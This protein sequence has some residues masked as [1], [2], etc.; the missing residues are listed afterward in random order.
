[1]KMSPRLFSKDVVFGDG[2]RSFKGNSR[3]SRMRWISENVQKP[4]VIIE[5]LQMLGQETARVDWRLTGQVAAGNIDIFVQSTIEMNVLTGR[6][7]SHKDS[8]DTG[9]MA[10][11][12]SLLVAASRAAWAARQAVM[13]A[14][15]KLS[16]A[17]DTLTSTLESSMDD[18]SGVYR[19]PTD[20][21]KFFQQ[22][23][24]QENQ[25]DMINFAMIAIAIW[26][27][28]KGFSTVIQ[29]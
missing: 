5:R 18:D 13:D 8:W 21:T 7:L 4:K 12:V 25:N 23:Q 14:Q 6:I 2:V 20:P 17:A 11:P 26:A 19:D 9:G 28:Y 10:P 1:M 24:K 29:L 3:Y 22:S 27:V 15:E 16:E